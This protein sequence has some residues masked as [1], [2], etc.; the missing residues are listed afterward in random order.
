MGFSLEADKGADGGGGEKGGAET[1]E[2]A[3]IGEVVGW[4]A[5]C[6]GDCSVL[7]GV[8]E[9]AGPWDG[10]EVGVVLC[11]DLLGLGGR[12]RRW[13]HCCCA[14]DAGSLRYEA[15]CCCYM[16]VPRNLTATYLKMDEPRKADRNLFRKQVS[17]TI[18]ISASHVSVLK[19][20]VN[21]K[22][23]SH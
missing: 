22:T 4:V 19:Q 11:V 10:A 6:E 23:I 3:F 16:L 21:F 2:G 8:E 18:G 14:G 20:K 13:G 12:V 1:G 17:I 15:W 5:A 7:C 9:G